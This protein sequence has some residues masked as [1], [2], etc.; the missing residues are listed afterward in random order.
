MNDNELIYHIERR[1]DAL[2]R[3][4]NVARQG[5]SGTQSA[6]TSIKECRDLLSAIHDLRQ[7]IRRHDDAYNAIFTAHSE[8]AEETCNALENCKREIERIG[9][10]VAQLLAKWLT[11]FDFF[12]GA[13]GDWSSSEQPLFLIGLDKGE[14]GKHVR[15]ST[16]RH[17]TFA[18]ARCE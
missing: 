2:E 11:H 6:E 16:I 7:A 15:L 10:N 12:N 17:N 9:E 13:K 18:R 5:E 14:G 8:R 3:I 1:I 4:A